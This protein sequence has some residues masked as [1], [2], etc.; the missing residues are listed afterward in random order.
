MQHPPALKAL[1]A[2]RNKI[3]EDKTSIL[4]KCPLLCCTFFLLKSSFS[5]NAIRHIG[6]TQLSITN[7]VLK[8]NFIIEVTVKVNIIN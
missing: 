4:I 2:N 7:T 6:A 8:E 5:F 3:I 1:L